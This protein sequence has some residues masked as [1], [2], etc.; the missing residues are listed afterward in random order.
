MLPTELKSKAD[1]SLTNVSKTLR[2]FGAK[3]I[4][5]CLTPH[6][7]TGKIYDLTKRGEKLREEMLRRT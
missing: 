7:K 5:E 4:I 6:N 1:M 2:S 3:G